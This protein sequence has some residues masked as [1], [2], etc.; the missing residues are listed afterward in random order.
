M[1]AKSD[2]NHP[3]MGPY[4]V[5]KLPVAGMMVAKITKAAKN[6]CG[7]ERHIAQVNK[8]NT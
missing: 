8:T 1:T 7:D 2:R 5:N 3:L 6:G 4:L